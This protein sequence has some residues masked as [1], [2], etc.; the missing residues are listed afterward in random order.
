VLR[1]C[2]RLNLKCPFLINNNL[3]S[4]EIIA[5]VPGTALN[6]FTALTPE[7]FNSPERYLQLTHHIDETT[8]RTPE[9]EYNF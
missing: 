6:S 2:V 7:R 8:K 5:H 4:T 9:K 1:E 3:T